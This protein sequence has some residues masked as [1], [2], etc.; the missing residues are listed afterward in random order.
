M[1][2][3]PIFWLWT[4]PC[5]RWR[6]TFRWITNSQLDRVS[7]LLAVCVG[8]GWIC[9]CLIFYVTGKKINWALFYDLRSLNTKRPYHS[10]SIHPGRIFGGHYLNLLP[11]SLLM[12]MCREQLDRNHLYCILQID[13]VWFLCRLLQH[14]YD[15][16]RVPSDIYFSYK[17]HLDFRSSL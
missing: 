1:V 9:F 7:S 5:V 15:W 11:A 13:E 16:D 6:L 2:F 17:F 14:W 3:T 10:D 8:I 4:H 12:W